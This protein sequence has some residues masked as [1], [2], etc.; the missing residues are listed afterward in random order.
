MIVDRKG[1]GIDRTDEIK[2]LRE[3]RGKDILGI[4]WQRPGLG[5]FSAHFGGITQHDFWG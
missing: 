3:E 2:P 1:L 4:T 5:R